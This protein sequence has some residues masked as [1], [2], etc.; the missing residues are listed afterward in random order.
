MSGP[1]LEKMD[2]EAL[3]MVEISTQCK[4]TIAW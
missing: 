3:V 1:S 2:M 4:F